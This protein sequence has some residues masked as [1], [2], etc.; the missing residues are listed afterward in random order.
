MERSQTTIHPDDVEAIVRDLDKKPEPNAR[1]VEAHRKAREIFQQNAPTPRE[2]ELEAR[3]RELENATLAEWKKREH[4]SQYQRGKTVCPTRA[5]NDLAYMV[6]KLEA[7]NKALWELVGECEKGLD[8]SL[9][10][11]METFQE[12]KPVIEALEAIQ[13]AKKSR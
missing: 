5:L 3:C 6:D 2:Q 12:R 9:K 7:Q 11:D 10:C 8:C 13:K 1:M 4:L